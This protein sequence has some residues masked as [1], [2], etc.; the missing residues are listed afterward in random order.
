MQYV[1]YTPKM[2]P[3]NGPILTFASRGRKKSDDEVSV[4]HFGQQ[5][6]Y[7]ID[8]HNIHIYMYT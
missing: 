7:E 1:K 8:M 6:D 4:Q 5:N 2:E 3:K